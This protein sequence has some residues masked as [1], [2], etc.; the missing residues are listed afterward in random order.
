MCV[1]R[2]GT[3]GQVFDLS[4]VLMNNLFVMIRSLFAIFAL[5][6]GTLYVDLRPNEF[7]QMTNDF[8]EQIDT[9]DLNEFEYHDFSLFNIQNLNILLFK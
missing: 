7:I 3:N 5:I 9:T 6:V 4:G 2:I 1:V 8:H